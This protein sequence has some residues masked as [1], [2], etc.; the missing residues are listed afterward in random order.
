MA[1]GVDAA[2]LRG[3]G[4]GLV[5]ELLKDD[6]VAVDHLEKGLFGGILPSKPVLGDD[7]LRTVLLSLRDDRLRMQVEHDLSAVLEPQ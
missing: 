2:E 4:N 1:D 6:F 7:P 3:L 5:S